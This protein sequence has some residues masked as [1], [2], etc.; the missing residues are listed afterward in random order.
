MSK[1]RLNDE[2]YDTGDTDGDG[3]IEFGEFPEEHITLEHEPPRPSSS[4]GD[5]RQGGKGSGWDEGGTSSSKQPKA[6]K[7]PS[8][9][10]GGNPTVPQVPSS[11][12]NRARSNPA[13]RAPVLVGPPQH[14]L[15]YSSAR[16][17]YRQGTGGDVFVDVHALDFSGLGNSG[18]D[19]EGKKAFTFK[20]RDFLVHGTVT[21]KRVDDRH[22]SVE[23]DTYNNDPKPGFSI[24][25]IL[26]FG[27]RMYHGDGAPFR[28]VFV[29]ER[30][31]DDLGAP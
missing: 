16:A 14:A 12:S 15:G 29:G 17:R 9:V 13:S 20:S 27:N 11:G 23:P 19:R 31:F 2:D 18:W 10:S 6:E 25:N 30:E 1:L 21:I 28:F 5:H 3:R 4:P 26:T 24:R 22:F 7:S 8:G